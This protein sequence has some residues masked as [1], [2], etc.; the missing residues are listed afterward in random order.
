[1]RRTGPCF[2]AILLLAWVSTFSAAQQHAPSSSS[3][4]A[5]PAASPDTVWNNLMA[6]NHRFM[7]G[8]PKAREFV[9]LRRKLAEG[10][11]PQAIILTCSDSRVPPELLFDQSLGDIFVVR[12]AGNVAGPIGIGSI[13]YAVDHLGSGV[14]VV[15]GHSKCGAVAAACSGDKMPTPNLQAIVDKISPAVTQAK[16]SAKPDALVEAAVKENVLLS[17]KD[18][19]AN[20]EV[21]QHAVKEGKLT[22]IEAE[23]KIDTGEVVRLGK[24]PQPESAMK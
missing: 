9:Q 20:S 15:L 6:G 23:Y 22:I 24:I 16:T 1:M 18:V 14:L 7:E 2:A 3:H 4:A 12:A 19:L 17:A 11:H 8:K 21:L 13:E 5:T 10:Q